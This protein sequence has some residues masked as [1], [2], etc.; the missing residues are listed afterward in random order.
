VNK[1]KENPGLVSEGLWALS[2]GLDLRVRT[3]GACKVNGVRYSTVDCERFLLTQ[4]SGVITDG[5]HDGND[6]DFYGVLKEVIELEYNLN[7]QVRRMVVLFR[8]DWFKLH[9]KTVGLRDDGYF[10]SINVKSFWY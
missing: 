5:S 6:I 7:F 10:K 3:C 4:K 9:G 1:H 8:C 2:C